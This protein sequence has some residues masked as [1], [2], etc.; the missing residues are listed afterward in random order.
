MFAIRASIRGHLRSQQILTNSLLGSLEYEAQ[1]FA[2][3]TTEYL[4]STYLE[5]EAR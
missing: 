5:Y 3:Q 2:G 1:L 4:F